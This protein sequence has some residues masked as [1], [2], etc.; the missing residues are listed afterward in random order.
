MSQLDDALF[1]HLNA[2]Q[3][4]GNK[5]APTYGSGGLSSAE[6]DLIEDQLGFELPSDF[7]H[8]LSNVIDADKVLFPWADFSLDRYNEAIDWVWSGIEFD[9]DHNAVWLS[10]WG[11]MPAE[12]EEAKSI[13][14]KDFESWPKLLPVYGHRFLPANPCEA[15]NPVFSIMQTDIIYYGSN[16]ADY[17][18]REF[19]RDVWESELMITRKIDVWSDFAEQTEGFNLR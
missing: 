17:L 9:I 6:L 3:F 19:C 18:V 14:R 8:L 16:L 7:R 12:I 13:A 1:E 10:R 2:N 5:T 15:N 4:T 11:E